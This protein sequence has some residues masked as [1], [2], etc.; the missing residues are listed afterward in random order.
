[1]KSSIALLI[2]LVAGTANA[3]APAPAGIQQSAASSVVSLKMANDNDLLRWARSSRSAEADDRI[4]ELARPLGVV[5]N[6]DEATGNV[7]VETV[8]AKGNAARSGQVR[9]VDYW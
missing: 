3:F 1:M 9:T 4:V 7:Y 5:L 2:T 6:V 8:A